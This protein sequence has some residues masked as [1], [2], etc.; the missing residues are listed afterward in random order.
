MLGFVVGAFGTL[1]GAGGGFVLVPILLLLYPE[2][3]PETLTAISLLVVCV[4]AAS[5]S[6]AY[7]LQRRIDYRSAWWFVIGTFPGAVVGAIVVGYVPRRLFDGIFS[8]V[9]GAVGIYLVAR[10]RVQAIAEP[11]R[12]RGVVRRVVR[13]GDGNTFVYAYQLWK[14]VLISTGV[15]FLSSLLGIGGGIMHVPIMA[16]VLH[17]PVQIATATSQFVL[18]FM[19]AEGSAVHVFQ[20][21]IGWDRSLAQALLLAAG[22]IPGAQAGARLARRLHGGAILRALAGALILVAVRLGLKAAGM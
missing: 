12:G 10:P 6:L 16:T 1:V 5:G 9:L 3:D 15:G 17:F 11:V 19:A 4:N 13:D 2:E 7:G 21:V 22:A 8:G 18:M 14:G 20:G